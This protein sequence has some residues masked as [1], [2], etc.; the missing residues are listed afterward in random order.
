[1]TMNIATPT[2]KLPKYGEDIWS[3]GL[4]KSR[5]ERE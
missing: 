3:A 5:R 1:M 2:D 4:N